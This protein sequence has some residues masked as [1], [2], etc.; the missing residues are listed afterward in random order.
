MRLKFALYARGG[1]TRDARV[2]DRRAAPE[3][4]LLRKTQVRHDQQLLARLQHPQGG[5]TE[6]QVV[7]E[8]LVDELVEHR[9]LE[10]VLP[11]ERHDG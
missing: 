4:L 2:H 6:G 10:G 9:V 8:G 5:G 1:A 3:V 7:G 11:P